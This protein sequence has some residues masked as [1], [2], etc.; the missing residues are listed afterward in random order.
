VATMSSDQPSSNHPFHFRNSHFLS[1]ISLSQ[2]FLTIHGS[3]TSLTFAHGTN[4]DTSEQRAAFI[5]HS[6]RPRLSVSMFD[7]VLAPLHSASPSSRSR[8]TLC[9]GYRLIRPEAYVHDIKNVQRRT[10]LPPSHC[11][12][13]DRDAFALD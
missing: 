8:V 10:Q 7:P 9:Y 13:I 1:S 12:N 4:A 2:V 5:H 6:V 3:V 11:V